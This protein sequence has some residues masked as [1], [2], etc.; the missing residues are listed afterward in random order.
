M[1]DIAGPEPSE[2]LWKRCASTGGCLSNRPLTKLLVGEFI[3]GIGDW[4]YIVA[5]FVVIYRETSDAAI[6]GLFGAVR[7]LPYIVLSVPAGVIA[8]RFDRRLVLI[9]SDLLRG[10]VMVLM[11]LI[12]ATDGPVLLLV[13][14][15]MVAASG[16]AFFYPAMAAYLPSLA[17]DERQ[18][19]P[20]EQRDGEHRQPEL[21]RRAG[22]RQDC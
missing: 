3:S 2:G 5:I 7:L 9:S 1:R 4:L 6:V 10:S 14:L 18:L 12:V 17:A 21:H 11:T 8:D 22:D 15:A 16:S 19:G 20:G 13:L